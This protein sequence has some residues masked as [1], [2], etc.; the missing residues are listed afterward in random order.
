MIAE[1][2]GWKTAMSIHM[3]RA[4]DIVQDC[5]EVLNMMDRFDLMDYFRRLEL[6]GYS[7]RYRQD[8]KGVIRAYSIGKDERFYKASEL[9][10]GRHFMVSS[11]ER[12]WARLHEEQRAHEEERKPSNQTGIGMQT[13]TQTVKPTVKK[14]PEN[15]QKPS[16][17]VAPKRD[18]SCWFDGAVRYFFCDN[19]SEQSCYIPKIVDEYLDEEF[20]YTTIL[21]WQELKDL[22]VQLFIGYVDGATSIAPSVGGGGSSSEL[23]WRDPEDDDIKFA[24]RC[25][26]YARTLKGI[27]K[28][29]G[30]R[31]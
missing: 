8:K 6:Y 10:K 12:T 19:Q 31:Y 26:A 5:I 14:K 20:D 18:Y 11:L 4:D 30:K 29:N 13:K 21:N 3:E 17:P 23:P 25:A 16:K 28:R 15:V 2:R 9:G 22:A 24:K 1:R 27:Q 7:I